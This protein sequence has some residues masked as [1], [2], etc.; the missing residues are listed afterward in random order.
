MLGLYRTCYILIAMLLSFSYIT[1]AQVLPADNSSIKLRHPVE[2]SADDL[3]FVRSLPILHVSAYRHLPPMSF[4]NQLSGKYEGIS[5]DIFDFIAEQI[6]LSYQFYDDSG[7][8]VD[9]K[10]EEFSLGKFDVLLPASYVSSRDGLFTDTYYKGFY[11]VISR[12]SDH[13]QVQDVKQLKQYRAGMINKAAV[14]SY[15]QELV[16]EMQLFEFEDG[17]LYEALRNNQI[18]IAIFNTG[19]FRQDRY[20]F[21]LF[22]LEDVYRLHEYPR[23]YGFIFKENEQN[24]RL[25]SIFNRYINAIDNVQSVRKHEDAEQR[26]V[27]KYIQTKNQ[28][29]LLWGAIVVGGFMFAILF[30]AFRSRQR[31]LARLAESHIQISQQHDALQEAN[32]QLECLSRTDVLTGMANRRHFDERLALEYAGYK[33]TGHALSVMLLDIDFFKHINDDY[34]H[35]V[36]DTYL[37][38]VAIVLDSIMVRSTD[39]SARYGGE[40]FICVLPNTSVLGAMVVADKIREAVSA[41]HTEYPVLLPRHVTVSIGVATL[42][43]AKCDAQ[44][45]IAYADAELYK[46]KNSGRNR[47]SGILLDPSVDSIESVAGNAAA[48]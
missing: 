46:A 19:V 30:I 29:Q 2:L 12:K 5:I 32:M 9:K 1:F 23:N 11:S 13:L 7:G 40:E 15:A 22:D 33:R 35:G 28:Q 10:I 38:K 20:R 25:V 27:E 31:M 24:E 3:A 18:D 17:V 48:P 26:L 8:Y 16:G 45:L 4:Y 43:G 21:E 42:L 37:K 41:L 36:G 6:G 34:G 14:V 44:Q 47:I 39:L